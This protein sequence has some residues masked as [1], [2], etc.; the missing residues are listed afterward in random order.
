MRRYQT[1]HFNDGRNTLLHLYETAGFFRVVRNFII[2]YI[3]RFM[4]WFKLKNA[5]YRLVGIKTWPNTAVGLMA[6]MDIIFPE[7]ITIGDNTI[8]GYNTTILCHEYLV[9]E[10]RKGEV[11]IGKNVMIGA[12]STILPGITIGDN[13]VVSACSLV[14][15]DVAP[16]TVVGGVPI[17]ELRQAKI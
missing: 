12:N 15:K 9:N 8:I 14:N 1:G 3:A 11:V 7:L 6:M 2:I 17:R 16:N 5:L 4:P 13:A 10:W